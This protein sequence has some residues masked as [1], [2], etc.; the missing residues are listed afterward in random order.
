MKQRQSK[1]EDNENQSQRLLSLSE[2]FRLFRS[3]DGTPFFQVN[4]SEYKII[5]PIKA[6]RTKRVLSGLYHRQYDLVPDVKN[7]EKV[8]DTLSFYADKAPKED[9]FIRTAK[10]GNTLYVDLGN[11][12]HQYI[13]I[14]PHGWD[15]KDSTP[16]INFLKPESM[17]P[18]PLP[19][20]DGDITKLRDFL[21]L[22]SDKDF[23]LLLGYLVGALFYGKQYPIA[24][25]QGPQGSAKSTTSEII[26]DLIDPGA[27]MLRSIPSKEED[28]FIA[29]KNAL[30]MC[31]D[32]LSGI[33]PKI[34]DT[35]CKIATGGAFAKRRLYSNDDEH[36]IELSRPIIINGIDDLTE[37]PDL[38]DRSVV[39]TLQKIDEKL[40]RPTSKL[41]EDFNSQK[42]ALFGCLLNAL[43]FAIKDK[44]I[45]VLDKKPRMVDFC[46]IACA[47][48]QAFGYT[49][50][51]TVAAFLDNRQEVA[52]DTVLTNPIGRI[53]V[54]FMKNKSFWTGT[55]DEILGEVRAQNYDLY[56]SL[57]SG[58]RYPSQF[59]KELRRI[60]P[61]LRLQGVDLED[62]RTSSKRTLIIK[63]MASLP[64]S[65]EQIP[66]TGMRHDTNDTLYGK[67]TET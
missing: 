12:Q 34:S 6:E 8:M 61:A 29:A 22:S 53:I 56:L 10:K 63:K 52:I 17:A 19:T 64:S 15:I 11:D 41:W 48:L 21:N 25:I 39:F 54:Y 31:F 37:R 66:F 42:P 26:K 27:P 60:A 58:T 28:I 45:I 14:T 43:V 36:F 3:M 9:V 35:L 47:G 57:N 67:R 1:T 7:L 44:D 50:E 23:T 2:C 49:P 59:S 20:R 32:N 65:P 30:L 38:A 16:P 13:E 62:H 24:I 33:P 40:R 46:I 51:E 4:D 18:L 55:V 5:S